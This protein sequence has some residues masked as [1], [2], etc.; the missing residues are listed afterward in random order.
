MLVGYRAYPRRAYL[1]GLLRVSCRRDWR[2]Q[3]ERFGRMQ[4]ILL[5][6]AA[7]RDTGTQPP[8]PVRPWTFI[9]EIPTRR[10][11][12]EGQRSGHTRL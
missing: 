1:V 6:V 9:P 2:A 4:S 12:L 10:A 11:G 8:S 3:E 7:T 5:P